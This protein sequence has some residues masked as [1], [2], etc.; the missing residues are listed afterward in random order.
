MPRRPASPQGVYQYHCPGQGIS[1]ARSGLP[2]CPGQ[3]I[4]TAQGRVASTR[5]PGQGTLH[6][7]PMSGY[8]AA[9]AGA[10]DRHSQHRMGRACPGLC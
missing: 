7:L 10:Q 4:G 1:T 2:H 8:S 5:A 3:G 6:A 9:W